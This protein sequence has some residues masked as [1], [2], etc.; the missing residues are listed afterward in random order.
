MA[1]GVRAMNANSRA[2]RLSVSKGG[3]DG[4]AWRY[5]NRHHFKDEGKLIAVWAAWFWASHWE[6]VAGFL[7][8]VFTLILIAEKL[9]LLKHI[10]AWGSRVW[11]RIKAHFTHE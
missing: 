11:Q 3:C 10:T 7:A 8:S 6:N 9:G 2:Q 5:L 4:R 1:P